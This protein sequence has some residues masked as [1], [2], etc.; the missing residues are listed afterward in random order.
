MKHTIAV[1]PY[2]V[3]GTKYLFWECSCQRQ[4]TTTEDEDLRLAAGAHVPGGAEVVFIR[5]T[6]ELDG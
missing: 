3:Y 1:V 2:Q 5:R 4:G 6:E